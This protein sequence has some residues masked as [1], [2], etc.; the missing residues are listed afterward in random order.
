M[1]LCGMVI[2]IP[3]GW[4]LWDI[5]IVNCEAYQ[6]AAQ[7]QHGLDFVIPA[8]RGKI[9]DRNSNVMAMSTTVYTLILS[10]RDLVKSVSN[11]DEEGNTLSDEVYQAKVAARQDQM[12]E[13]LMNLIPD[14]DRQEVEGHVHATKMAYREI[15]VNI[16][17]EEHKRIQEYIVENKAS[18]YLYQIAG[19]KRY[20]P[21]SGLAA[22]A[23]GFVNANGGAYGIEAVYNDVLEGTAGRVVTTRTAAGTERYNSYAEYIDAVNGYNITLTIDT[24][25]QSY[26]EKTLEEGIKDFEV[27][28]GAFAIAMNPKTGAIY[29]IASSP[30][31]DPNNYGRITNELLSSQLDES[32]AAIFEKLKASNTENLTDSQLMEKAESQAYSDAVN[33]Q[34]RNKAIDSRYEPGSVFKA[35]VLAAALEE[36]VVSENDHFFCSGEAVVPGYPK[37]IKCSNTRGHKD[38]DLAKAVANSCNP[39][40]IEIGKRLGV[41]TFYDYFEAFGMLENTG[42]D[43]PGEASLAGAVWSRDKM[44]NVDLAVAS[45]GQRFEIT[46]LQM[47]CGFSAVINGGNLVKPYVVQS[48]STQDGTVVQNT[49]PEVV[50][51]VISK[52]TSQRAADILEQVVATG[53]G[54]NG[55]VAGY[56]IGGKTGT[57]EVKTVDLDHYVVSFMG[58]APADDPQVIVLLAY[59]HPKVKEPGSNYGPSGVYISGGNMAAKKA[60]PLIAQILDYLGI[61]KTYSTEEAAAADVVMP[62]VTGL[63]VTKA[64]D[65]LSRVNLRFR[66]IGE[67]ETVSR[68]IPAAGTRIPGG[69]TVILYLGDSAPEASGTVPDVRGMTYENAKNAL[70]K[71]GFFMRASGA[72]V[73]YGNT[74]TAESQSI[75]GGVAAVTGTVVDV[76]FF[77]QVEDGYAG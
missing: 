30:D 61:E 68:Q 27:Q 36:G 59:D 71:A 26:L 53:S 69:S 45:F 55:Y 28:D 32:A 23:L 18:S 57:S 22:Q 70:E 62:K 75:A 46:P 67:G 58:Y 16:E 5:A 19:S 39:A 35:I 76:K 33:T 63:S 7:N 51:Q 17:E 54:N 37:P 14:L 66:T 11:K 38:Q 40:F 3:L 25:I 31:F 44:S 34:W 56:R 72:S 42:I 21:Y 20:Y 10:P 41:D 49:Q 48:V 8:E 29:G 47:I 9:Y 43:L 12:V 4:K 15:K 24:T 74:T 2:F 52:Q 64:E 50:R 65:D 73:Y 6:K 60:G 13:E 77:N 1:V